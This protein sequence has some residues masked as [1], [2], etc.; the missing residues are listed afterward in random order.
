MIFPAMNN[1]AHISAITR[2]IKDDPRFQ[3]IPEIEGEDAAMIRAWINDEAKNNLDGIHDE[4]RQ[5]TLKAYA[6]VGC[7]IVCT[8]FCVWLFESN[9]PLWILAG[10]IPVFRAL[11]WAGQKRTKAES[12][13]K[14]QQLE[15]LAEYGLCPPLPR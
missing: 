11:T 6:L 9:M 8:A 5:I 4:L 10:I 1:S 14:K 7:I 2:S 3:G 15:K 13:I 12:I